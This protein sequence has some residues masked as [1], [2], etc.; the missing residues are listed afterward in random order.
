[1]HSPAPTETFASFLKLQVLLN[2]PTDYIS[3]QLPLKTLIPQKSVF[4]DFDYV[5][6]GTYR[7][8][9]STD[10]KTKQTTPNCCHLL[11]KAYLKQSN[12]FL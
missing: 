9:L 12:F 4:G 6:G 8:S 2:T 10:L 3:K 1:M 11:S 5:A 7:Q